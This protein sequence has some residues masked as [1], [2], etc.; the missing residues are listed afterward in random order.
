MLVLPTNVSVLGVTTLGAQ[1]GSIVGRI[2][3]DV[4]FIG[5]A[6]SDDVKAAC[7]DGYNWVGGALKGKD[8]D[9]RMSAIIRENFPYKTFKV[10]TMVPA[11]GLKIGEWKIVGIYK[12]IRQLE[13]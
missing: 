5:E 2:N 8:E 11:V 6:D 1:I 9:V 4:L 12:V 7:P 13:Q 10:N 3:P